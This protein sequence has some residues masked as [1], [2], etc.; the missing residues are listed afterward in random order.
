MGVYC[1]QR[2]QGKLRKHF[3]GY[4][5]HSTVWCFQQHCDN[6]GLLLRDSSLSRWKKR[7]EDKRGG[8]KEMLWISICWNKAQ[9]LAMVIRIPIILACWDRGGMTLPLAFI[10]LPGAVQGCCS[11]PA[12]CCGHQQVWVTHKECDSHTAWFTT[13]AEPGEA[14]WHTLLTGDA[15]SVQDC[16]WEHQ[17]QNPSLGEPVEWPWPSQA[18]SL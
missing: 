17:P 3:C 5:Y 14:P 18:R 9:S 1:L 15:L 6:L 2:L 11:H 13:R 16:C 12:A 4:T 7:L 10:C 8:M